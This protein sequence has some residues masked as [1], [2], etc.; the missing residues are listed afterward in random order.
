MD[1]LQEDCYHRV[2]VTPVSSIVLTYLITS[3]TGSTG[4]LQEMKST[5]IIVYVSKRGPNFLNNRTAFGVSLTI[6]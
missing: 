6:S 3:S 1:A 5:G 2:R 4:G